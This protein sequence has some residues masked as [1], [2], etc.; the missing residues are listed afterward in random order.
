MDVRKTFAAASFTILL[1]PSLIHAETFKNPAQFDASRVGALIAAVGGST[2]LP[3]LPYHEV[4]RQV[5]VVEPKQIVSNITR[6]A[7]NLK[8]AA[9][10]TM[11]SAT[12]TAASALSIIKSLVNPAER[13][14]VETTQSATQAKPVPVKIAPAKTISA[15]AAISSAALSTY[16]IDPLI[17]EKF[18]ALQAA[19]SNMRETISKQS[20][21][22]VSNVSSSI[23][24]SLDDIVSITGT[25]SS[26]VSISGALTLGSATTT[27]SNGFNISTGCFSINNVCVGASSV[28]SASFT[29]TYPLLLSGSSVLS[30]NFST[31]TA[32]SWSLLN[33]FNNSSSTVLSAG[34]AFFGI[35]ATS[36]FNGT[37][38]LFVVG[39]T[40]LQRFTSTQGTTTSA[41]STNLYTTDFLS[42]GSTT[43]QKLFVQSATATNLYAG[44]LLV[45]ASSSFQALFSTSATAT[46]LYYTNLL[47][48]G[49]TTLQLFTAT[50]GT[51]TSA[52]STNLFTTNFLAIGSTTLQNFFAQRGT[53]TSATSTNLFTTDFL[54]IGSTTLQ[55]FFAQRGTTTSATSTNLYTTDFLSIGSTTLQ[56]FF[57]AQGTTT[58]ATSTNLF[59]TN[60][61]AIGST[62]LQNFFAAQGTTTSATSTNLY[63]TAFLAIGSTTLQTFF[64][65]QGTTTSATSTNLF[66]T[67]FLAIGSTT[68]QN[69]FTQNSTSTQATTTNFFATTGNFGNVSTDQVNYKAGFQNFLNRSTT[70]LQLTDQAWVIAT[71]TATNA[72]PLMSFNNSAGTSTIQFFGATTT[73]LTAAVGMGIP[74]GQYVL[75]GDGKTPS[76]L[77][78][79]KGGLCVDSDGWCTASTTGRISSV[80]TF[81]GNSDLA[82]M[83]QANEALEPG[84]VV[85]V[86]SGI[87]VAKAVLGEKDKM[88]GVVSTKPGVVLGSGPDAENRPGDVPI[89]LAGRVPLKVTIENGA[90]KAGD[91]L[92]LSSTPGVGAKA[93]KAGVVIGQALEGYSGGGV[94]KIMIFVKNSYYSGLSAEHLPGLAVNGALPDSRNVLAA[95]MEGSLTTIGYISEISTDRLMAGLEII[96]PKLTAGLVYADRIDSPTIDNLASRIASLEGSMQIS[97]APNNALQNALEWVGSKVTAAL[98]IFTRV[99]T[100]TL[101]VTQGIEM[102]DTATGATYCLQVTNGEM[103][104]TQGVCST[105]GSAT[106]T[107]PPSAP[108]ATTT[109]TV[110]EPPATEPAPESSDTP[111]T[112]EPT[113]DIASDPGLAP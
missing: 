20:D 59:T 84:D 57:A 68:L 101:K 44:N 108:E 81:I 103:V 37:G 16:R 82:E 107:T 18:S 96:T 24:R 86:V 33:T 41:T 92:S 48:N 6:G 52:T 87:G 63:T 113:L 110:S 78:I 31:T 34:S 102:T 95:L 49:S 39:S 64:A 99:E 30:L 80:S 106:I 22:N 27:A 32:N 56:K 89:A 42:I 1:L 7:E 36:S 11:N 50:A 72:Y 23:S 76:G 100:A 21:R 74:T 8:A 38:D 71:S 67:N 111:S 54:A 58:S 88:M 40:T 45:T 79:L 5:V 15:P 35:T 61:L 66:T 4:V 69:L 60:F 46:N 3:T 62:T 77:N 13:T 109:D 55:N 105:A 29:A 2:S 53:T 19:I 85:S 10:E 98:G 14:L 91:Y 112:P 104:K 43:L 28:S 51:T 17:Q 94:G 75:I 26:T 47:A 93:L 25:F 90:I 97:Q 73:G 70:T 9:F 12:Q 65:S 83:Y